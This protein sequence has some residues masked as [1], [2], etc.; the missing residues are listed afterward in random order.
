[1][2]CNE[3]RTEAPPRHAS[4]PLHGVQSE[5][6]SVPAE[7]VQEP[8]GQTVQLLEPNPDDHEPEGHAKH[9]AK[10]GNGPNMP[11]SHLM[12]CDIFA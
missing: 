9:D 12:H 2:I 11:G 1:M 6:R 10:P 7:K 5:A 4:V 8:S 3:M